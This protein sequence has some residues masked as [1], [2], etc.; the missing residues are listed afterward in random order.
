MICSALVYILL[1]S[2]SD[3]TTPLPWTQ[4]T[5]V[6]GF[7]VLQKQVLL[8]TNRQRVETLRAISL[9]LKAF[10]GGPSLPIVALQRCCR[11]P[12][13]HHGCKP[14]LPTSVGFM[15]ELVVPPIPSHS[16]LY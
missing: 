4:H 10:S 9:L 14:S 16:T 12:P 6:K 5:S 13:V 2:L 15:L 7:A 8:H 1:T 3:L 11:P